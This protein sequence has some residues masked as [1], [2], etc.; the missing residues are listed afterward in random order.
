[1][2]LVHSGGVDLVLAGAQEW[3]DLGEEDRV[4]LEPMQVLEENAYVQ[5]AER[6]LLMMQGHRATL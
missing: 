3:V 1:M 6:L 5:N 4:V 2:E